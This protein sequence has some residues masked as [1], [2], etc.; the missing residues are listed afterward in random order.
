MFVAEI[1]WLN[2]RAISVSNVASY[3]KLSKY[4]E[5]VLKFY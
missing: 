3:C 2:N 1:L 4:Y 5:G